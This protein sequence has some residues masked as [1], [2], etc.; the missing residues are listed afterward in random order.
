MKNLMK[1]FA[2]LGLVF[3]FGLAQAQGSAQ[4]DKVIKASKK[5]FDSASDISAKFSYTLSNPNMKKPITKSGSFQYKKGNKYRVEFPD[6]V[7][8]SDRKYIWQILVEDEEI[9]KTDFTEEAM[10]PEKIF[11]A[12]EDDTKSRYDGVEGATEKV[13]LFANNKTDELWKTELWINKSDKLPAKAKMHA[14]N[15]STYAY[16]MNG[17]KINGGISDATFSVD[18]SKYEDDGFIFTDLTD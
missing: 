7:I 4:A 6:M 17:M 11:Q 1:M 3:T 9:T 5:K 18:E 13:T 16:T 12:Y 10:G 2:L 15:G 14:R 8:V